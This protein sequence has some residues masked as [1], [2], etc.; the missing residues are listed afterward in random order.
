LDRKS[1]NSNTNELNKNK[2][3]KIKKTLFLLFI[4]S[5]YK[6]AEAQLFK[7]PKEKAQQAVEG[8]P[9]TT[10]SNSNEN[11]SNAADDTKKEQNKCT[12]KTKWIPTPD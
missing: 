5:I 4:A 1:I 6:N 8:K 2:L 12:S 10:S 11:N 3:N 7:K 9:K